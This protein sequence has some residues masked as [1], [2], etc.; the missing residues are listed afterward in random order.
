MIQIDAM[1]D[2][3][4]QINFEGT[5]IGASRK[6]SLLVEISNLQKNIKNAQAVVK[7]SHNDGPA[8]SAT[9]PEKANELKKVLVFL[10]RDLTQKQLEYD[11][12]D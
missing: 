7:K 4:N 3:M 11:T 9:S 10:N 2:T 8:F 12:L 1:S 6:E 5:P